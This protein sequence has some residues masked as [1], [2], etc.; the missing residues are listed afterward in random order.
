MAFG[1]TGLFGLDRAAVVFLAAGLDFAAVVDFDFA[2]AFGFDLAA[3]D[4][5]VEPFDDPAPVRV[6]GLLCPDLLVAILFPFWSI[7]PSSLRST[8]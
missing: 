8:P 7:W 5:A 1:F 6:R 3:V 2:A 4:F